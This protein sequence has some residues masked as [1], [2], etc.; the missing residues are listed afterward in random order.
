MILTLRTLGDATALCL[1]FKIPEMAL[2][3]A[4]RVSLLIELKLVCQMLRVNGVQI[5]RGPLHQKSKHTLGAKGRKAWLQLR[6][7]MRQVS[8]K[9]GWRLLPRTIPANSAS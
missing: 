4:L 8:L 9:H 5:D 2:A 1:I 7:E 6:R 3:V